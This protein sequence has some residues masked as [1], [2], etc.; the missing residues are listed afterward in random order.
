MS[1][2]PRPL[3]LLPASGTSNLRSSPLCLPAHT[4]LLLLLLLLVVFFCTLSLAVLCPTVAICVCTTARICL[5]LHIAV[6]RPCSNSINFFCICNSLLPTALF[7]LLL[8]LLFEF[9]DSHS[10]Y[11]YVYVVVASCHL[12]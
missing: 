1:P 9:L 7:R 11:S 3:R 2:V 6:V 5:L 4:T 8:L 10:I 12:V